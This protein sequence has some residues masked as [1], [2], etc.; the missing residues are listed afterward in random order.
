MSEDAK[1]FTYPGDTADVRWDARLC[2]HIGE[3]GRAGGDLF[4]AGRKPWCDPSL[5]GVDDVAAVVERC[6][7]GALTHRRK[8]G[9]VETAAT[10]NTVAIANNGPLYF[11][12]ELAIDGAADDMDGV[13]FRA[14]LCRCGQSKN[15]PFCDNTHEES[16]FRDR[17]AVGTVGPGRGAEG[18]LLEVRRAENG[19]LLV[20]GS[21]R[22]VTAAGRVAWQGTK[23]ALCR[24][25]ASKNK[26][27]CDGAH[28]AAGF[29][30]D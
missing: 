29:Q 3:C 5:G 17:G 14:A 1:I 11:T 15:K 25:G 2:I 28:K 9:V 27:F 13:A 26:P 23:A 4:V 7:T 10:D 30:A 20:N 19:P 18:G 22:I 24:C 12:G 6:P 21:F 8:D 16:G